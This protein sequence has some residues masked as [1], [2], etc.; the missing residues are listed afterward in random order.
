MVIKSSKRPTLMRW[1]KIVC[2]S[3]GFILAPLFVLLLG[4]VASLVAILTVM[5]F[6]LPIRGICAKKK[7]HLQKFLKLKAIRLVILVNGILVRSTL[8]LLE[9]VKAGIRSVTFR[10]QGL[11]VLV[12]GFLRSIPSRLGTRSKIIR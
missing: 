6:G 1:R 3:K 9:R 7:L 5:E 4:A 2:V 8:V 12:S 11:M 10:L